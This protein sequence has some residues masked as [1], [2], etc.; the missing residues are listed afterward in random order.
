MRPFLLSYRLL[1]EMD[2]T[3]NYSSAD[4]RS[5]PREVEDNGCNHAIALRARSG[6]FDIALSFW[7]LFKGLRP[8]GVPKPEHKPV[9]STL[10]TGACGHN[11]LKECDEIHP[12]SR[13]AT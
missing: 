8:S 1:I 10:L 2:E 3:A 4:C 7:L 5:S 13:Q 9:P 11:P 6:I 12:P